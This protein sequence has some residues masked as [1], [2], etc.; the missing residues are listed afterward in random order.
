MELELKHLAAYWPYKLKCQYIYSGNIGT[1]SNIYTI[2]SCYDND[3]IKISIDFY[4]AEHIWM[5]KPILRPLSDLTKEELINQGFSHHI[6]YLTHEKQDP[7]KAPYDMV[8]YLLSQHYDIFN[9]IPNNLAI[10]INTLK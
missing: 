4:E 6:D 8:Q 5:F 9:L 1:I 2:G 3:D 7:L 10:D